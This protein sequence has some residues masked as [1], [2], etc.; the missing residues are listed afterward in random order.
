MI[1]RLGSLPGQTNEPRDQAPGEDLLKQSSSDRGQFFDG[2]SYHRPN[3]KWVEV[4]ITSIGEDGETQTVTVRKR[5]IRSKR[6]I[7]TVSCTAF[8]IGMLMIVC[9]SPYS[10]EFLVPGTLSSNHAQILAGQGADRCAACHAAGGGSVA[11]WIANTLSLGRSQGLTQSELCMKCHDKSLNP[12]AA[13]NPH[14]VPPNEMAE[15]SSKFQQVSFDAS[16][17]FQPPVSNHNIAC[18][19]CHREHHGSAADLTAMTDKQCQSCHQSTFHSFATDHPEFTAYPQEPSF[20]N[21][22]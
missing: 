2:Q 12:D 5:S 1:K 21:R 9:S 6:R 11:Q 10:K 4:P 20:A 14:N 22:V 17:V 8:T 7:F 15:I 18:N 16:M 13:L 3:D 19:A